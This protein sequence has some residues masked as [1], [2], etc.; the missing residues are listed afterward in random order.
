MN[1]KKITVE[2]S[3]TH[4]QKRYK[5]DL[6]IKFV[7]TKR[8][9]NKFND[10][11]RWFLFLLHRIYNIF[12]L[13]YYPLSH[14]YHI[15]RALLL[16]KPIIFITV[17]G[18]AAA[19]LLI[20]RRRRRHSQCFCQTCTR[21]NGPFFCCYYYHFHHYSLSVSFGVQCQWQCAKRTVIKRIKGSS[22]SSTLCD[23][24][25]FL[26]YF[27]LY[28]PP[29]TYKLVIFFFIISF[30]PLSNRKNSYLILRENLRKFIIFFLGGKVFVGFFLYILFDL[31][32]LQ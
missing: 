24:I 17:T 4:T 27:S 16:L 21:F 19:V 8:V 13:F 11:M 15:P 29:T 5:M 12:C 1:K 7:Q 30:I 3:H 23:N 32:N 9:C 22:N 18:A 26:L 2:E 14:F 6:I 31:C 10:F 25:S 28:Y 20:V